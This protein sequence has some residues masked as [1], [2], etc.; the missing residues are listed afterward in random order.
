MQP[1]FLPY[2]GY[3]QL[4]RAVDAFVVYDDI[5]YTKKGWINRNRLL[6]NGRD[7]VFSL[8]LQKGSDH[9]KVCDRHLAQSFIRSKLLA[10][11]KGAYHAAPHFEKVY[12]LTE[13]IIGCTES[14]LFKY[15]LNSLQQ[16]CTHLEINTPLIVSSSLNVDQDLSGK[17]RVIKTCERLGADTYVNPIGGRDLY[18]REYFGAHDIELQFLQPRTCSYQQFAHPF[19]P[20]LSILDVMMF[21]DAASIRQNYLCNY[22]LI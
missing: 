19:V 10:K 17:S 20:W 8:P 2:I 4:I 22:D 7:E 11:I 18:P 9:L 6:L 14:N 5:K 3:F 1:Y 12:L 16:V 15:I 13:D 21:N